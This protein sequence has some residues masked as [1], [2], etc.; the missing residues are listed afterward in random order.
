VYAGEAVPRKARNAALDRFKA[1]DIKVCLLDIKVAARGLSVSIFYESDDEID[2]QSFGGR[3]SNVH[4]GTYLEPRH[5]GSSYQSES[6]DFVSAPRADSQRIHRIGQTRPTRVEI[7]VTQD[8]F[9]EDIAKRASTTRT[10]NEEKQYTR[11]LIEV[12]SSMLYPPCAD[13]SIP[14]SSMPSL[15]VMSGSRLE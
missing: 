4:T 1:T 13:F 11:A 8:T 6:C 7:L 12:S 9:E 14:V 10:E 3:K 2:L 5:S 15:T